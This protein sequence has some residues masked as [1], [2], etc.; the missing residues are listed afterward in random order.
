LN[1][2]KNVEFTWLGHGTFK[3]KTPGGKTLL[4]DPWVMNNPACPEPLKNVEGVEAMLISH[5]HF[6]HIADA[7][8]I[9]KQTNCTA[10]GIFELATWLKRKGVE[11]TIDMNKGGTVEVA[12]VKVT[13][14]HAD[15]SC[16]IS[17]DDGSI[18]YGGEAVGFVVELENGFKFYFSGDT[19]VFGDMALIRELYQPDLAILPIGG[20]YVMGPREAAKAVELLGVKQVIPMHYGTFPVLKGHPDELQERVK[21]L[22]CEVAKIQPGQTIR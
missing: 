9:A 15:H 16:G 6:D 3:V 14:V 7:V 19:N 2:K 10:L 17:E 1:L 20:H 8:A 13:M 12:G 18:V 11:N 5:G 22:G 4:L 21:A